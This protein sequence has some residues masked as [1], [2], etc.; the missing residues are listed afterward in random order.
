MYSTSGSQSLVPGIEVLI[1]GKRLPLSTAN[2]LL[3]VTVSEDLAA[4]GMFTLELVT[5]DLAAS[6]FT[7]IDD[8]LFEVGKNVEIRMGYENSF[9]SLIVGEITVLEPE[10]ARDDIPILVVR[11]HDLRH[12]LMRGKK[13]RS[14]VQM[15]DSEIVNKIATEQ[16]LT[17]KAEDNRVKLE[18]VL[19]HS[20][21]DLEFLQSR[22][23]RL[24]YELVVE[25]KTLYFRPHQHRTEK[26][27]TLTREDD[28]IDFYPRL[29]SMNQ[30]KQVEVRG[31]LP[32]QKQVA[33]ARA[34]LGQERTMMGGTISGPKAANKLFGASSQTIVT[35]PLLNQA[36]GDQIA[37]GQFNDMA[38]AYITGEGNCRGN[39]QLRTG[40]VI[41]IT[42]LGQRF[43]GLYYVTATTHTYSQEQG[44]YTAFTVRRNA[45]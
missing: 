27:L 16:G 32:K 14:F 11:G 9:T 12:R 10:F 28:L 26:V 23:D 35:Q 45:T 4:P 33:I 24:G 30:V 41:E 7:W 20:Q 36:E 25:A 31:W 42:G 13:T 40:K 38:I 1:Q 18:Y 44:Y 6:R 17:A 39:P 15:K 34:G 29:S 3:A 19:Q 8:Q 2:D 5:W 37:I 43:S 22:A 21:T